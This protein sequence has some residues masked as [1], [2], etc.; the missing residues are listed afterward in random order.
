MGKLIVLK[1]KEYDEIEWSAQAVEAGEADALRAVKQARELLTE[2]LT[3]GG[4]AFQIEEPDKSV[5]QVKALDPTADRIVLLSAE[6]MDMTKEASAETALGEILIAVANPVT[7]KA[8]VDIAV[9]L[10]RGET[11]VRIAALKIVP[12]PLSI[13]LSVAQ[14]HLERGDPER[15]PTLRKV[16]KHCAEAQVEVEQLL[17]AAHGVA[18][19][20]VAVA[21]DRP[22]TGLILLGWPGPR[23]L[24]PVSPSVGEQVLR[25]APCDIA[26]F[27]N[28][29]LD[30]IDRILVP[31]GDSPHDSLALDLAQQIAQDGRTRLLV[32]RVIPV[33]EA[34]EIEAEKLA[35]REMFQEQLGDR[36][37]LRVQVDDSIPDAI[38]GEAEKG[39]DVLVM[40]AAQESF[41]P[42]WLFGAVPDAVA[43]RAPC[44]VLLVKKHA[45]A[46]SSW[47]RRIVTWLKGSQETI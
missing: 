42:H 31:V 22:D 27:L 4:S 35:L 46:E 17:R 43:E 19:G 47:M 41:L 1:A 33:D 44:S 18:S 36:I 2:E 23:T 28:K 15:S 13:P 5:Q 11:E 26:L 37:S 30:T 7:A 10:A 16:A 12:F 6:L 25:E 40:G 45:A 34:I 39:C 38:V 29:G 3:R 21:E 8:L 14:D 32:L 24:A 9:A 20:I